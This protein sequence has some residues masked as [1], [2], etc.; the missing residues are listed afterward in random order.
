MKQHRLTLLL[1]LLLPAL[2]GCEYLSEVQTS[3]EKAIDSDFVSPTPASSGPMAIKPPS[4]QAPPRTKAEVIPGTGKFVKPNAAALRSVT[5]TTSGDITL[6]FADADLREVVRVVLSETL[7][8]NYAIDPKV[9]GKV[10]VQTSQPISR[11]SVLPVLENV[12]ALNGAAMVEDGSLFKIVPAAAAA[13]IGLPPMVG[14][15]VI[16]GRGH[17]VQIVPLSHVS[18]TEMRGILE[19]FVPA[20]GVLKADTDRNLLIMTGT[21]REIASLTDMVNTFDVDWLAGMSFGLFPLESANAKDLIKD[22]KNVFG[23]SKDG[24]DKSPLDGLVR[25]VPIDRMNAVLVVAQRPDYLNRARDWIERLDRGGDGIG[26]RLYVYYI[27]NRRAADLAPVLNEVFASSNKQAQDP[28]KTELA[29]GLETGTVETSPTVRPGATATPEPLPAETSPKPAPEPTSALPVAGTEGVG[30]GVGFS[31]QSDIRIIADT[32]KNALLILAT[33]ADYRVIEQALRKLDVVPLQV[34]IEA[35]IAE[36]TLND[37]L[38]YGIEWFYRSG[39]HSATLSDLASGA[40]Q[41]TFPGFSYFFNTISADVAIDALDEVTDVKVISSPQLMVLDNETASLQVGDQ[42]PVATQ[43]AVTTVDPGAPIVNSIQ[44]LNTGVI[45]EVTPRV[46]ANGLVV[47][48]IMQEVSDA[49]S[50]TTSG[51]DSPT[52]QR[53]RVQS[54]VAVQSGETIALGGLIKDTDTVSDKGIPLFKE[55]PILGHL[56]KTQSDTVVRTELLILLTPRV[57]RDRSETRQVTDELRRRLPSLKP[58]EKK[59]NK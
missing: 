49:I 18:A 30:Q 48:D 1:L 38:R 45:L 52:I 12:L 51:I 7:G 26:K 57:V 21:A 46:N 2:A 37:N 4:D 50:T 3:V 22:L 47:L 25:F 19:P 10:T 53:R 6:N 55:I 58:L 54:T 39:N 5:T 27:E 42:V 34:L 44:H 28:G 11:S 13:R 43:S 20:G 35:T 41:S 9:Q 40:V 8:L 17:R 33:P 31:A 14:T 29:P 32:A 36:V 23:G 15:G 16:Q 59:V 24:K 56:F